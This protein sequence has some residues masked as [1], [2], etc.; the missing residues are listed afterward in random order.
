M[1]EPRR[2]EGS[3]EAL[4]RLYSDSIQGIKAHASVCR[5]GL[6]T[7]SSCLWS[8]SKASKLRSKLGMQVRVSD[9]EFVPLE[10]I[11]PDNP[12]PWIS[13]GTPFTTQF[14]CFTSTKVQILTHQ[15]SCASEYII[16]PA[17]HPLP[18][19]Q[20]VSLPQASF[21]HTHTYTHT[22]RRL[23]RAS[24]CVCLWYM[25]THTRTHAAA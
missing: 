17:W 19:N 1:T 12:P 2:Y 7:W 13:S 3:I 10:R 25:H 11:D 9:V 18:L 21:A 4:F 16:T 14:T 8:A 22:R 5:C 6:A 20:S 15:R 24:R 23:T